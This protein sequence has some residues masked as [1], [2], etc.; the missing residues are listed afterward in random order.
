MAY[1]K[2]NTGNEFRVLVKG[3][4]GWGSSDCEVREGAWKIIGIT[5]LRRPLGQYYTVRD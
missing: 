1:Q 3:F 4:Q 2:D 5:R